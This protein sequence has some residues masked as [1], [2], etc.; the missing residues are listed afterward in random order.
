[1]FIGCGRDHRASL[2]FA[3]LFGAGSFSASG[4]AFGCV[5]LHLGCAG[6]ELLAER[7]ELVF[8]L[9]YHFCYASPL[10]F[11]LAKNFIE[12]A[13]DLA[14]RLLH[15]SHQLRVATFEL[16]HSRLGRRAQYGVE[17]EFSEFVADTMN[18]VFQLIHVGQPLEFVTDAL[19]A[20]LCTHRLF[21]S[22]VRTNLRP[23]WV[24]VKCWGY[25]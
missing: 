2:L 1:M 15:G 8:L 19:P 4:G 16:L 24:S 18:F 12:L 14:L 20:G 22:V 10:S 13:I 5:L 21:L 6:G 17:V 11:N 3:A 25:D 23:G 9:R 7:V